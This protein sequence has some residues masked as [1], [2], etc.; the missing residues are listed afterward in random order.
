MAA[1][2]Y[3]STQICLLP[4]AGGFLPQNRKW[5]D[6]EVQTQGTGYQ[7]SGKGQRSPHR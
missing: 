7:T 4:R 6:P 1:N 5:E 3:D 2:V